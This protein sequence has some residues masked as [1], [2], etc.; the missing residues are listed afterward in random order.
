MAYKIGDKVKFLNETGGGIVRDIISKEMVSVESDDGFEI[1][2]KV[3]DIVLEKTAEEH[4]GTPKAAE[5]G[6]AP[7]EDIFSKKSDLIVEGQEDIFCWLALLPDYQEGKFFTSLE[8]YLINDSNYKA[9]YVVSRFLD[10]ENL[11]PVESG[12][13]DANSKVYLED[14]GMQSLRQE[15]KYLVQ[16]ILYQVENYTRAPVFEKVIALGGIHFDWDNE[17]VANEYFTKKAVLFP[18]HPG[19]EDEWE[20]DKG[21]LKEIVQEKEQKESSRQAVKRSLGEA[22]EVDLHIEELTDDHRGLS[23]QEILDIQMKKFKEELDKAIRQQTKKIIFIHG[24][25]NGKLRFEL[26]NH[27]NLHH[28]RLKYQDAS[29]QEYG[30]GATMV[31]LRR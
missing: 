29:F 15:R 3:N 22:R 12:L 10:E 8:S 18:V 26:R 30:F 1:P 14:M 20:V 21:E 25:G 24:V 9:L 6:P 16:L 27:L 23:N 13:L 5:E 31:L 4:T 28:P 11:M 17:L 2:V 7:E 19:K